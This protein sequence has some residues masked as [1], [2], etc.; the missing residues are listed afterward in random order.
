MGRLSTTECIYLLTYLSPSV[1]HFEMAESKSS[2]ASACHWN[3]IPPP[4]T[5]LAFVIR[6]ISPCALGTLGI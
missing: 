3:N 2:F 1:P 6:I 5:L 4:P